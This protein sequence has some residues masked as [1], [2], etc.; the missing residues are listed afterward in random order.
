MTVSEGRGGRPRAS[1]RETLAEAACELFLEQGYQ[2]TSVAD[3]AR[4]AGVSRAS[5]FNYVAGKSEVIWA[6]LDE[7]IAHALDALDALPAGLDP[8]EALT[9]AL[10]GTAPDTL[11]L[12]LAH[13]TSM[14]RDEDLE[15]EAALRQV[16]LGRA[17]AGIARRRGIPALRAEIVGGAHGAAVLAALRAWSAAGAGREPFA[18]ALAAAFAVLDDAGLAVTGDAAGEALPP[19]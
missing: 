11:S 6:G 12:V 13:A 16:R 3:I 14:G 2:A 15:H 18:P 1:S 8:R 7:R 10:A 5:F 19:G 4:R 17:V 9:A